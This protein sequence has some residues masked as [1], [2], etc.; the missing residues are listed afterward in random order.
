MNCTFTYVICTRG[1]RRRIKHSV[2]HQE[3]TGSEVPETSLPQHIRR[4]LAW[5]DFEEPEALAVANLVDELRVLSYASPGSELC[6]D[7]HDQL[8]LKL[9][10]DQ[11]ERWESMARHHIELVMEVCRSFVDTLLIH[12]I[13]SE[14]DHTYSTIEEQIVELFF[15]DIDTALQDKLRELIYHYQ[16]AQ[17]QPLHGEFQ[18]LIQEKWREV[19]ASKETG[20]ASEPE[21]QALKLIET[22]QS[23]YDVSLA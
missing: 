13:G 18:S 4:I 7:S 16:K 15:E 3:P 21:Q 2:S 11:S 22:F 1:A 17:P 5:H 10:Q 14:Y 23:Y 6:G 20:V 8:A 19:G 9:F 12:D